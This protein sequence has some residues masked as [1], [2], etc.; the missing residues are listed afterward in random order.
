MIKSR[1]PIDSDKVNHISVFYFVT[2][3]PT[4]KTPT[5]SSEYINIGT[6]TIYSTRSVMSKSFIIDHC[7]IYYLELISQM[8][9]TNK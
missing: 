5:F 6:Y 2:Y 9:H 7:F 4:C 1:V 3:M 8:F